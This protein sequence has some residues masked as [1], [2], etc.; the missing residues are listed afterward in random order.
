M[1]CGHL[2]CNNCDYLNPSKHCSLCKDTLQFDVKSSEPLPLHLYALG[3]AF[4][5]KYESNFGEPYFKTSDCQSQDRR[6]V[7]ANC[8]Q[9]ECEAS[10]YCK[11]CDAFFCKSCCSKKH[12][13]QKKSST[14]HIII[15]IDGS[16][17]QLLKTISSCANNCSKSTFYYCCK[18]EL[19]LCMQCFSLHMKHEY[20][21]LQER[22]YTLIES[23]LSTFK[24][25]AEKKQRIHQAIQVSAIFIFF[26]CNKRG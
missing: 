9:C 19:N 8:Y 26:Y 23:F 3:T 22:N 17:G 16:E 10:F 5:L 18:C 20:F 21:T 24:K 12:L 2:I 15:C 11:E 7:K 13:S 4:L 1:P 25:A 14:D 6:R